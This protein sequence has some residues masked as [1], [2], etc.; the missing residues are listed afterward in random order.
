MSWYKV[1]LDAKQKNRESTEWRKTSFSKET[2]GNAELYKVVLNK[3][4][5]SA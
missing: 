2:V 3:T 5:N 4:M 1:V